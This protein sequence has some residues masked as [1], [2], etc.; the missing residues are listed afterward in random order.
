MTPEAFSNIEDRER[1]ANY[2][3]RGKKDRPFERGHFPL[4][5]GLN[6][7]AVGT[8]QHGEDGGGHAKVVLNS[9]MNE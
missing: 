1:R 4:A 6:D 7:L 2:E 5:V 9:Q 8:H 3:K